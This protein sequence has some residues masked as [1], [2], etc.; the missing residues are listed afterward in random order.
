MLFKLQKYLTCEGRYGLVFFY[1][2]RLLM[3]FKGETINLPHFLLNN[4]KKMVASIQH[5]PRNIDNRLYHHGIIKMLIESKLQKQKDNWEA[6]LIR[7][8]FKDT[9]EKTE[10]QGSKRKE[11]QLGFQNQG[12][13]IQKIAAHSEE[14][15]NEGKVSKESK[16]YRAQYKRIREKG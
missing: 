2:F 3:H 6:F 5:S 14:I 9:P 7:N 12:L 10:V 15:G 4:L 16:K 8:H 11:V 13:R 1:H